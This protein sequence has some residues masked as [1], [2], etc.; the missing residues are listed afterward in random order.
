[1]NN[2]EGIHE[3][4]LYTKAIFAARVYFNDGSNEWYYVKNLTILLN[5]GIPVRYY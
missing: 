4:V 3:V 1:M 5:S 2:I